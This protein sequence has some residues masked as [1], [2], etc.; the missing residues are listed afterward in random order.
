MRTCERHSCAVV[1][2]DGAAPGKAN[3]CTR[4]LCA[5]DN[6][7]GYKEAQRWFCREHECRRL[8]CLSKATEEAAGLCLRHL[9]DRKEEEEE[10]VVVRRRLVVGGS[11]QQGSAAPPDDDPRYRVYRG[12]RRQRP[13][14]GAP[15]VGRDARRGA[16][17]TNYTDVAEAGGRNGP[18]IGQDAGLNMLLQLRYW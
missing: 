15:P 17:S 16:A 8:R 9:E 11:R 14:E 3:F 1:G 4:H 12:V 10:V 18:T 5:A 7:L 6:C 13:D 2:C